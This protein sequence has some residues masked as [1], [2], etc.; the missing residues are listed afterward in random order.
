MRPGEEQDVI[1]VKRETF[2][3][4]WGHIDRPF[5]EEMAR[6]SHWME[7]SGSEYDP[8][9]WFLALDG[10]EIAGVSLNWPRAPGGQEIGWVQVLGVR[11]PWRKRGLGLALLL[12]TF[13][14]YYR[15]GQRRIG[16]G[17]DAESLTGATRLYEKAGMTVARTDNAY[18]KELRP[19]EDLGVRKLEA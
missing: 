1:R 7:E 13:G 10:D 18:E 15:R 16:L 19:G 2:S 4:H 11:R 9:L 8:S 14:E 3:D 6:W 5:D 12:H 17:V